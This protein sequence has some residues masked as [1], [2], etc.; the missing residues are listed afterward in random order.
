MRKVGHRDVDEEFET[1]VRV[2]RADGHYA[3]A[4]EPP[5]ESPLPP[6]SEIVSS[7]AA[8]GMVVVPAFPLDTDGGVRMFVELWERPNDATLAVGYSSQRELVEQLGPDQ[9]WALLS[10]EQFQGLLQAG[11]VTALLLDPAPGVVATRWSRA[12]TNAL[13]AMSLGGR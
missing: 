9:P 7:D 1:V 2:V 12:A 6:R 8:P 4:P 13:A 10:T 11:N 3:Q 5:Q